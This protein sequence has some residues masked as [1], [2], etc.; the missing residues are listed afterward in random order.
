MEVKSLKSLKSFKKLEDFKNLKNF[1]D[2]KDFTDL[3]SNLR[4][5]V[6]LPPGGWRPPRSGQEWAGLAR[7]GQ[8]W[9][10]AARSGQ[11]WPGVARS[12]Q[13]WPSPVFFC[14]ENEASNPP[15]VKKL[16]PGGWNSNL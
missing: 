16:P 6:F 13:E 7:S 14:A 10:G 8:E 4:G 12:G 1:K 3:N 15:G 9:P 2:F 5:V 11:E